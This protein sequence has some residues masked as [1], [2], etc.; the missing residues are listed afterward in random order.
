MVDKRKDFND[1]LND[2]MQVLLLGTHMYVLLQ[3][4]H[5]VG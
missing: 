5:K 3:L 2:T 1:I 4:V